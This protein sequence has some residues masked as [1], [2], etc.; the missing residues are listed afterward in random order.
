MKEYIYDV[1]YEHLL[2]SCPIITIP[3]NTLIYHSN[4][5]TREEIV[6]ESDD[7]SKSSGIYKKNNFNKCVG[8][9]VKSGIVPR[10]NIGDKPRINELVYNP[11]YGFNGKDCS[12]DYI[13]QQRM[14]GNLNF[15][16]N[17]DIN[18]NS[19]MKGNEIFISKEELKILDISYLS[20]ELGFSPKRFMSYDF[21]KN[22]CFYNN[23]H[24]VFKKQHINPKYF[25]E[26]YECFKTNEA[27]HNEKLRK[28]FY[29]IKNEL[30]K[31][32][33]KI[34]DF[35]NLH[36][37]GNTDK[38]TEYCKKNNLD[39]IITLDYVDINNVS[40]YQEE[41]ECAGVSCHIYNEK[42]FALCPEIILLNDLT[43]NGMGTYKL[44]IIGM[45][46]LVTNINVPNSK[47]ILKDGN[48]IYKLSRE[49]IK[50]LFNILFTKY[51]NYIN[52]LYPEL[53]LSTSYDFTLYKKLDVV[54]KET[55]VSFDFYSIFKEIQS[56]FILDDFY[57]KYG[58]T[59]EIKFDIFK[60]DKEMLPML[61]M[62]ESD[63]F[64]DLLKYQK[65]FPNIE[66][67]SLI[68]LKKLNLTNN[69]IYKYLDGTYITECVSDKL[70]Y[71]LLDNIEDYV[72]Y[73]SLYLGLKINDD[74]KILILNKIK[75][76]FIDFIIDKCEYDLDMYDELYNEIFT[77]KNGQLSS[78]LY[79]DLITCLNK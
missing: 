39:G 18:V 68:E 44:E 62:L 12:C 34:K 5:L 41:L 27:P 35:E 79:N 51:D 54:S 40:E 45:I 49:D 55:N 21:T 48:E 74:S 78:I 69:N 25:E 7:L 23:L 59:T 33:P 42:I 50:N 6:L 43:N 61:P 52:S 73:K 70:F 56:K 10:E 67:V 24:V 57:I 31:I 13:Q 26:L 77:N 1:H 60:S 20:I 63:Y 9:K 58:D 65:Y 36:V 2:N 17:I 38:Y 53:K 4:K 71:Y 66:I 15:V 14:Y 76:N 16:G 75:K 19:I 32:I 22:S 46:D 3:K 11:N 8:C 72:K 64:D 37:F 47:K 28:Q 29:L 30:E